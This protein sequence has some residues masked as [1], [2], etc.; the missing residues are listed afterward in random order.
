MKNTLEGASIKRVVSHSEKK[1]NHIARKLDSGD[2]GEDSVDE[3]SDEPSPTPVDG[4]EDVSED[5]ADSD[6]PTPAP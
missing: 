2:S 1:N 4:E 5:S 6:E 3:G